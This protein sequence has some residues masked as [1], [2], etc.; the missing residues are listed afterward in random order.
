MPM[1]MAM[2]M[3]II[4]L[5]LL[6]DDTV[7]DDNN[8]NGYDNGKNGENDDDANDDV[9]VATNQPVNHSSIPFSPSV[10]PSVLPS[11]CWF[12][13]LLNLCTMFSACKFI[14][15]FSFVFILA[16]NGSLHLLFIY[17]SVDHIRH[18]DTKHCFSVHFNVI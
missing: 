8:N 7:I 3:M 13:S 5:G 6:D 11:V 14:W 10:R 18:I 12:V 16:K 1:M 2:M 9:V 15:R 17:L 4:M